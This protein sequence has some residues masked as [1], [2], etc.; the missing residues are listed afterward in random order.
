V[1]K[2][3]TNRVNH[4]IRL[5]EYQVYKPGEFK[6]D[7]D[8]ARTYA[9]QAGELS[10][11]LSYYPGE[12]RSLNLLG[13]ISRE[14]KEL[15]QSMGYHQA[16]LRLYRQHGDWQGEAG[17]YLLL[18]WTRR[19]KGDTQGA[20]KEVQKAIDIHRR[21]GY[22]Q[23]VAQAYLELGNTYADWDEELSTKISYYQQ[24]LQGFTTAQD[25][26]KQADVHKDLADLYALHGDY[27]QSLVNSHKALG[28]YQFVGHLALQGVYDLLGTVYSVLGDY[29]EGLKYG[30]LAVRTAEQLP[31][32]SLQLCTIY[33]RVGRTY[34]L[35]KQYQKA[36]FYYK[37]SMRVAQ[38]YQD[39]ASI[40][41]L[42]SNISNVLLQ[43]HK[44]QEALKLLQYLSQKYPPRDRPDS[45]FL[46]TKYLDVYTAL[47]QYELGQRY[48]DQLLNTLKAPGKNP[49]QY[50]HIYKS[51]IRFSLA[52]K[53]HATARKYLSA[54]QTYA[55]EANNLTEVSFAHLYWFRLD[56]MQA[57][58]PSAIRHYQQ[59]K[60]LEDSLLNEAKNRQ[61]VSLDVLYETEKKE[62]DIKLKEQSIKTL[63]REKQ[64][65]QQQI[66]QDRLLRNALVGG[67]VLLLLL[68][69]VI[70]N[71]YRLKQRSNQLLQAQ[72][73]QLQAKQVEVEDKNQLLEAKQAEVEDKNELL[74]ELV[75]QK[76]WL[77][78]EVHHRVKNNLQI[79]ISLLQSQGRYLS[80]EAALNAINQS[81]HRVR[82]MALIHQKL[83]RSDNLSSI[84]VPSYLHEVV[85][86]LGESFDTADRVGFRYE[87]VPLELDVVQAVPLG[88]IVNEAVTNALKYAFPGQRTGT[89]HLC[90]RQLEGKH[91][92]L[93][94]EDDG[95]GLPAG[96]ALERSHS[97]G[98]KIMRG[99]SRQL[100]GDLKVESLRGVKISFSFEA[101][102]V[103]LPGSLNQPERLRK[104]AHTS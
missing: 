58:Y 82:A 77:L 10:R 32:T 63:T 33:N 50:P 95:V 52:S 40:L 87:L 65:Q 80:D 34:L 27:G 85:E 2:S 28:L 3:D 103:L 61:I 57:N 68:V 42:M 17:T 7:M 20:R 92:Q 66:Q 90:L 88:L 39:H 71:R 96:L 13:T 6:A 31:D 8:S 74:Q 98:A 69:G 64:L 47:K 5:G 81:K 11:K 16:A 83:Y 73:L 30:L 48:C 67:A 12:A 72:Q 89:V 43:L 24:A 93:V 4:L 59:H 51:V 9:E 79:I 38:K 56:S 25:K 104:V 35:L 55:T 91:Y 29:Q 22:H 23:G 37:K 1:G 86:Q 100:E 18:A 99:L 78:K 21:K 26:K 15:L 84:D 62:Q 101:S 49:N 14:S 19:D 102:P 97:M 76:E 70:Y 46:G 75:D 44:P 36:Y 45:I 53:Q 94:V 60:M 41:V 54:L